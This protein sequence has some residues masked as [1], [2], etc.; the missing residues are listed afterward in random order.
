MTEF[1][2]Q[3]SDFKTLDGQVAII[4]GMHENW[5]LAFDSQEIRFDF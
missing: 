4:T 5:S 1:F 3:D 2:V